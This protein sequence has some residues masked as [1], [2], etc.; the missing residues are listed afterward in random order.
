LPDLDGEPRAFKVIFGSLIAMRTKALSARGPS[1]GLL[2]LPGLLL[3]LVEP[4]LACRM[5]KEEMVER[6]MSVLLEIAV[7]LS[8]SLWRV[9]ILN[10]LAT[11][12]S[13]LGFLGERPIV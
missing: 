11:D 12:R 9:Q 5:R 4:D 3:K 10:R 7:G 1:L 8:P 13:E 6:G 2:P